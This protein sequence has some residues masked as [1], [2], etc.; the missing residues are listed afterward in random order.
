M[1][2]HGLVEQHS[3]TKYDKRHQ[4]YSLNQQ[5]GNHTSMPIVRFK[6]QIT[7]TTPDSMK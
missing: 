5:K 4:K 3:H 2:K 6:D 7:E 1:P